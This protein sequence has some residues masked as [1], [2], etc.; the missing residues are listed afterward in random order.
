MNAPPPSPQAPEN[1]TTTT[2]HTHTKSTHTHNNNTKPTTANKINKAVK[3]LWPF[4]LFDLC[5]IYTLFIYFFVSAWGQYDVFTTCPAVYTVGQPTPIT[6]T[7]DSAK[8][9]AAQCSVTADTVQF[10]L[11]DNSAKPPVCSATYSNLTCTQASSGKKCGCVNQ[12]GGIFTFEYKF[13]PKATDKSEKL[14]CKVVCFDA[15]NL[16]QGPACAPI[17]FS[18]YL[19]L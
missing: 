15:Q 14:R 5:E 1:K 11:M 18:K 19:E 12:E 10:Y 3:G 17:T 7:I 6:C 16:N 4:A 2:K 13:E 9:T 8:V